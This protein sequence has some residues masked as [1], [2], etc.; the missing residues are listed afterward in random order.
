MTTTRT[1]TGLALASA[2]LALLGGCASTPPPTDK[3]ALA[4]SAIQHAERSG[5]QQA[6]P[7]ELGAAR[8]KLQRA[9]SSAKSD[10]PQAA[11]L[12]E[13][14]EADATL[15]ES[16]AEAQRARNAL[17]TVQQSLDALREEAARAG[18]AGNDAASGAAAPAPTTTTT[19][20][21]SLPP[22]RP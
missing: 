3:L 9:Q 16:R 22:G 11:R 5:A 2:V 10:A 12:A 14:A 8:E 18:T 1:A 4:E 19:T 17:A 20:P 6:A 15:A 13:Q 21:T 7:G